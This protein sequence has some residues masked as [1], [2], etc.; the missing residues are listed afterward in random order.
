MK[1]V[2]LDGHTLNPGD[3][4][5]QELEELGEVRVYA[6]TPDDAVVER[7]RGARILLTNKTVLNASVLSQLPRLRYIGVLATGTNVVD[8]QAAKHR[9]VVVANVPAYGVDSVAQ[10]CFAHILNL[11]NRVGDHAIG[12][13]KGDWCRTEDF[14]YWLSPQ[15]ELSGKTLSIIGYGDIG[16]AVAGLALA[17]GMKVLIHTRTTP[18]RLPEGVIQVDLDSAFSEADILTLHCPLTEETEKI[19]NAGRLNQMKN[20]AFLINAARG[21]LLDEVAIAEALNS[22]KL[23]GAGLDVLSVEPPQMSNP[24]LSAKNCFIT[25]HIA[26][27][28]REARARLM[29]IAIMN[30]QAYLLGSPQ[31]VV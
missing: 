3:L 31:N 5:W 13:T 30:V 7:S 12:V 1:I 8:I 10:M 2:V 17:F 19:V 4:G 20:G 25:P 6:R 24:L 16:K 15:I 9:G 23:G 27:A 18:V 21:Q 28:T 14:C 22:G 11:T 29:A 26:W